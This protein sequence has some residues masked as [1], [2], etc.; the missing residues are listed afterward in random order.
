[1]AGLVMGAAVALTDHATAPFWNAGL[2]PTLREGRDAADVAGGL[3]YGGL[4]EEVLLHWGLMSLLTPGLI[5]LLPRPSALWAGA[6][7]AALAFAVAHL[8]AIIFEAGTITPALMART[9]IWNG[10]FG[11]VYGGAF[12]RQGLEAAILAHMATHLGFALA[13]L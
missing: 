12:L 5:R 6:T 4:T 2:L 1:M 3:L 9:L 7:I 10:L 8:P 11:L 13:A